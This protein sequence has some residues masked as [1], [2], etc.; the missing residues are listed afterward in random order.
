MGEI[1]EGYKQ[2]KVRDQRGRECREEGVSGPQI[3]LGRT[4]AA[5]RLGGIVSSVAQG[6]GQV[7]RGCGQRRCGREVSYTWPASLPSLARLTSR[8]TTGRDRSRSRSLTGS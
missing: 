8:V 2:G 1:R 5:C 7:W 6:G 3:I 4:A